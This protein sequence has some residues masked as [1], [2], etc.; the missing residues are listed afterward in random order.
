MKGVGAAI[1]GS[2][3]TGPSSGDSPDEY[4][5][6]EYAANE[7]GESYD[8][9]G[10]ND[11]K[12][13]LDGYIPAVRD[14]VETPPDVELNLRDSDIYC[15]DFDDAQWSQKPGFPYALEA[16]Y[17]GRTDKEASDEVRYNLN[18]ISLL[19]DRFRV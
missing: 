10:C 7:I 14:A 12:E 3:L 9:F 5:S 18:Q 11:T 2:L 4:R 13:T 17:P 15:S 16:R 6:R 19:T 8:L 1:L